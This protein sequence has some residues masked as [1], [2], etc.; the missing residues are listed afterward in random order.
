MRAE[1]PLYF[2][3]PAELDDVPPAV[4]MVD[5]P[6][7][8]VDV[9]LFPTILLTFTERIS[10]DAFFVVTD[11]VDEVPGTI[12]IDQSGEQAIAT[13]TPFF[14]LAPSTEYLI[15]V[16]GGVVDLGDNPLDQDG[17]APGAQA[18]L[19]RFTTVE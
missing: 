11:G 9:P 13:F 3:T 16:S 12:R 10:R 17:S 8:A 6:S 4:S 7:D 18:F 19:S 15:T 2:L 5:P 1:V 14:E